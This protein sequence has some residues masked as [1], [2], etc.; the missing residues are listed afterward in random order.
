[1]AKNTLVGNYT[2]PQ[3]L[4]SALAAENAQEDALDAHKLRH[5]AATNDYQ[6][7]RFKR[8]LDV[9]NIQTYKETMQQRELE[10]EESRVQRLI[11]QKDPQATKG[12]QVR[13]RKQRWDV[14]PQQWAA[15]NHARTLAA[16]ERVPVING[17]ALTT[18][19]LDKLLPKGYKVVSAPAGFQT[20]PA[21]PDVVAAPENYYVP[22]TE[23]A[24]GNLVV[25]N[26]PVDVEGVLLSGSDVAH[27]GDLAREDD[28]A[29]GNAREREAA[30][31][32][33]R[34][35]NGA[36]LARKRALRKLC[37]SAPALGAPAIFARLLPLL[38]EPSADEAERHILVKTTS[39]VLVQ[40]DTQV[41]PYTH[42]ILVAVGPLLIDENNTLRLE[43]RETISRLARAVGLAA[44]VAAVRPD[45]DHADEYVR[46]VTARVVAVVAA[47][48]GVE[49][50][51]PFIKAV[52]RLRRSWT[53][54]HTGV[55]IVQHLCAQLGGGN[56]GAVLPYVEALVTVLRPGLDDD[57]LA[58]RTAAALALAQ[59][60]ET[61]RPHGADQLEPVA[62]AA[63]RGLKQHRG[64][65]LAA[66]LRCVAAVCALMARAPQYE[67]HAAYYTREVAQVAA[68]E[69][70]LVDDDVRRTVLRV[71]V[72]VR[73]LRQTVPAF[74]TTV[75]VPFWRHFWNRRTAADARMAP[76]VVDAL[77]ALARADSHAVL[78]QV[79][80]HA[81]D[82]NEK[83]RRM[84][85]L[86]LARVATAEGLAGTGDL[87]AALVDAALFAFQEQL[88]ADRAYV[89]CVAA[90]AHALGAQVRDHAGALVSTLLYRMK[91]ASPE[92]RQQALEAV[93]AVVPALHAG[94][95]P[96]TVF[97]RLVVVIY[98]SLG[99]VYPEV[100]GALLD[101]LNACLAQ[102]DDGAW[103]TLDAPSV[104]QLLPTLTPILKNRHEKVQEACVRVVGLV[105]KRL[106]DAVGAREWMRVCF[107][108]LDML[109]SPRRRIRVAANA[110]FGHVAKTIGPQD[111][112]AML[113]NNLR[114][115]E[116]QLRVCTAVAIG[117][118]AEVCAPFTVLPALM[119]EYR[120][121]DK[122]VQNG[123]LKAL[124]FL[125]EYISGEATRS[126]LYAMAPLLDDALTDRDLVH[127]QTAATVVR[128]MALN[129]VG[130]GLALAAVFV[131][132]LNL[133][134]PNVYETSPHV[135]A[136]VL[137][138]IDAVRVA[139]G[140]GIFANYLWAGLFH[141]ARRVR[142]PYWKMYNRAYVQN[143]DALVPCYP[144]ME[145]LGDVYGI[146]ELD[147]V[148]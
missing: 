134:M 38:V 2:L 27:F 120:V 121:P 109:K 117:I 80:T 13:R 36:P 103:R 86:A 141:P 101:A 119:N 142:A 138:S 92:V 74:E 132:F 114:M 34:I 9:E 50:V 84:A 77:V 87:T 94:G 128:H 107:E 22:P 31:M 37:D 69:F 145:E 89:T 106:P 82:A 49:A 48:L 108:L 133:L 125:F 73:M 42:K 10:R 44:V 135:I 30:R 56:G 88:G 29:A 60:A 54:R 35:K 139:V 15:Q 46:N 115:Q 95:V 19:V 63:W 32:L 57:T 68:R 76:L 47:T 8:Q 41:R 51:L 98:E 1:M 66:Y 131:H 16:Q 71:V 116:R 26:A 91:N 12:A 28:T 61:V 97:V 55:R 118:V 14:T 100:L 90:V 4:A 5:S 33:L 11:A 72:D 113:L 78:A 137:E 130:A 112:L 124:G 143:S 85:A 25:H 18:A 24:V 58:V 3:A 75:L 99:E 64:R 79:A 144:R 127:R 136:R 21:R 43:A 62:A 53:A 110:T 122:N 39:R 6:Q 148:L 17:V 104:S 65:A 20:T 7:Q 147:I 123:V 59:L 83:M 105:A 70:A 81:R 52:V 111:V 126:Y 140:N 23:S 40:L 45:L 96:E 67:E 129:C 93:A 102:L 146:D